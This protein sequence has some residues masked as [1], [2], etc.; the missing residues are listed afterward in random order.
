MKANL[1]SLGA[2]ALF[3][4]GLGVAGMTSPA[5][6]RGFLDVTGAWDPSLALVMVGAIAVHVVLHRAIRHRPSPLFHARFHLPTKADLD[7]GLVVGAALFGV[8]WG[9]GGYCP[10][11]GIVSLATGS[12]TAVTFVLA[13]VVGM[14]LQ[15]ATTREPSRDAA[16][17]QGTRRRELTKDLP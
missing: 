10:G 12:A 4:L 1:A 2:G 13:M 6:V 7:G 14:A 11:P 17:S 5:K 3:G 16:G 9:L 15:H 8:G